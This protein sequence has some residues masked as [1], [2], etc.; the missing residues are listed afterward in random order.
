[1]YACVCVCVCVYVCMYVCV[2]SSDMVT[3]RWHPN[4]CALAVGC[5]NGVRLW[6]AGGTFS[7]LA[8]SP[9]SRFAVGTMVGHV[10]YRV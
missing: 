2:G 6:K 9:Q 1:M 4:G 5:E 3:L 8:T 7:S 10:E